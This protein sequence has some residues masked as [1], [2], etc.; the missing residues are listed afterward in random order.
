M[1]NYLRSIMVLK[2]QEQ[3]EGLNARSQFKKL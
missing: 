3:G 1:M 2:L